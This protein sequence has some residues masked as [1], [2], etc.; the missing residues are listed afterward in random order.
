[1]PPK[2]S[3]Q[4]IEPSDAEPVGGFVRSAAEIEQAKNHEQKFLVIQ[5]AGNQLI[6]SRAI[7][8]I[9]PNGT[10]TLVHLSELP[11]AKEKK[12]GFGQPIVDALKALGATVIPL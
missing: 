4:P 8:L 1:M 11:E 12:A 2:Q 6:V 5:R 10:A 3:D 9:A 7:I